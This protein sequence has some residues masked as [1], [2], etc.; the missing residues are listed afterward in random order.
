MV[1]GQAFVSFSK[2][3]VPKRNIFAVVNNIRH[4]VF[5]YLGSSTFLFVWS[6]CRSSTKN[7]S[8]SPPH[9]YPFIHIPVSVSIIPCCEPSQGRAKMLLIDPSF[10]PSI[11]HGAPFVHRIICTKEKSSKREN[12]KGYHRI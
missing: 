12:H 6:S 3:A 1:M 5:L 9:P 10:Y 4:M 2:K 8:V 11:N 7:S